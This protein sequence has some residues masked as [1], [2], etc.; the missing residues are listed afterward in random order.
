MT[1]LPRIAQCMPA[2]NIVEIA[3]G[4]GRWSR[5]LLENSQNYLGFDISEKAINECKKRFCFN[6][7]AK[8]ILSD[9]KTLLEANDKSVDFVFS[10]DSLVHAEVDVIEAYIKE[11]SR[12]LSL[13]GTGFIH[14]PNMGEHM[15]KSIS[16]P[17]QRAY[18]VSAEIFRNL[19]EKYDLKV[20]V[21]EKINWG[22]SEMNDCFSL[23][24]R[25]ERVAQKETVIIENKTFQ[26]EIENASRIFNAYHVGF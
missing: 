17:H 10:M 15:L 20:I 11:F 26:F 4:W 8:F 22:H 21:S 7:N 24:A 12:V 1:I 23:F 18:S 2:K 6:K 9:G 5:F 13:Y 25:K 19:C 14:H 16:N 3:P